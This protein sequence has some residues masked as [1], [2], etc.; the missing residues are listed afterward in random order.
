M[1]ANS[2]EKLFNHI[3]KFFLHISKDMSDDDE[4]RVVEFSVMGEL[5]VVVVKLPI[6]LLLLFLLFIDDFGG[7][8][9]I[10]M[11]LGGM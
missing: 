8:I 11:G 7:S 6:L 1:I 9:G 10:N 4:E 5:L 3:L 2:Y